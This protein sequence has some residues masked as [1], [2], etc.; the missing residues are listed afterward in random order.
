PMRRPQ[1][2]EPR[3]KDP[4]PLRSS[5]IPTPAQDREPLNLPQGL[6]THRPRVAR[7]CTQSFSA[8]SMIFQ[9]NQV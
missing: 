1:L 2:L 8:A 7:R 5:S 6:L 9:I 3:P 4:H